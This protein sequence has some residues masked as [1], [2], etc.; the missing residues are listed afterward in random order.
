MS[1]IKQMQADSLSSREEGT[2]IDTI[3]LAISYGSILCTVG[4]TV[5]EVMEI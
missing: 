1:M 2:G 5:Q 4:L 3:R